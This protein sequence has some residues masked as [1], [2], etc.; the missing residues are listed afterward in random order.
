[1]KSISILFSCV[2]AA[3]ILI[4]HV[5]TASAGAVTITGI[6]QSITLE[7]DP[8]TALTTVLVIVLENETSQTIRISIETAIELGLVMLNGD[9][10]PVI[11][12]TILGQPVEINPTAV[13]KE[14]SS[15]EN[16]VGS[17]LAAFF[18]D[19]ADLDY[20][21]IMTAYEQGTGFGVIAQTLWLTKKMDGD[22]TVFL[23]IVE[24]KKNNDFSNFV[25]LDGSTPENWGQFKQ[26]VLGAGNGHL[27]IVM[28]NKNN[29]GVGN[30]NGHDNGNNGKGNGKDKGNKPN[31]GNNGN[32]NGNH[33]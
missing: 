4:T 8:D 27:G 2:L 29:N 21:T 32:G 25:L 19:I 12:E 3:A 11:N 15:I 24:A 17:A 31:N 13:I 6:V 26:A 7:A 33:P 30:G 22:A 23:A 5:S 28:K 1:M 18:S 14:E 16:P 10:N 20:E 9:G